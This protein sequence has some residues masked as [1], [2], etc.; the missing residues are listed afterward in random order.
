MPRLTADQELAIQLSEFY[1]DP[2][3]YVMFAF[4]WTTDRSIQV[5]EL[6]EPWKSKYNSAF[7][8]DAWACEFLDDLGGQIRKRQFDGRTAVDPIRFSTAS[9]HGIGKST[10]VAWLIKFILDTRP[11]SK[12]VVTAGTQDQLKTKTW[13]E[14]GKWHKLSITRHLYDYGAGRGAMTL[15]RKSDPETW[16]C[17]AQTCKEENSESFAGLHAANSTPFYIFDEASSIPPKIWEVRAGGLTDGEPMVFDFGNPTRNSGD[18]FENCV[19]KMKRHYI[20]RSI[21]S[22]D[23]AITNKA[24]FEEMRQDYGEDSDRFKVRCRGLFPASGNTQ[25]N[26]QDWV[27]GACLREIPPN[28][29]SDRGLPLILGVDVGRFG[30]DESVI[31]PRLG[32]DARSFEPTRYNNR[33]TV[34]TTGK[35]IEAIR[36]FRA[37]GREPDGVFIDGTG[38]GGAVVDQ[39]R[40]L[41]YTVTEVQAA[42]TVLDKAVYRFKSDEMWGRMRDALPKL[43]LPSRQTQNGQDLFDQLTQREFGYTKLGNKIHLESKAEMEDRGIPSPN[44]ADALALTFAFEVT[45]RGAVELQGAPRQAIHDYDPLTQTW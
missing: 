36:Y 8:P 14:L 22:R 16:R 30:G 1:A 9:G 6:A 34:F 43:I 28:Y 15:K 19:G 32:Y 24:Y 42:G 23:V 40:S 41:G 33:D 17:D 35:V 4:P 13:A 11:Y 20:V 37:L 3:G 10:L 44:V 27:E 29:H 21:D 38:I 25:F 31:Y 7:G 39:L 26:P 45:A 2:L 18:F 12:G 5:V